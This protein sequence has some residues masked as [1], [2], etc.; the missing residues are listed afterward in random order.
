M[1]KLIQ[2]QFNF[3]KKDIIYH[4]LPLLELK[5]DDWRSKI[6]VV[7]QTSFLFSESIA[8]NISLGKPNASQKEIEEVA[9]LSDIHKDIIYLPQGYKTQVGE[10][11]VMLSGGQKQRIS[12]ARALLL[13]TEILILD[14]ALSAVDSQTENNILN[15][16]NQWKKNGHSLIITAHRLS[17]LI[18]SDEIIV[19]KD[20]LIIQ[21]GN[22]AK[23]IKEENWYKSMYCYQQLAIELEDN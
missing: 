17:A 18:N 7:N 21:R 6:A 5:I 2:R 22:H 10:R 14:D 1:L 13:N 20:G 4:S 11:G 12:I 19:I 16:I 23:L 3:N 15:N 8:N 9:K